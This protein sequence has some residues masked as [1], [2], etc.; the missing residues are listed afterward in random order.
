[1]LS[2][3]FRCL[4]LNFIFSNSSKSEEADK[5]IGKIFKYLSSMENDVVR[6]RILNVK[7]RNVTFE[8][9]CGQVMD[10]TFAELCDRPLGA[11]DYIE[12]SQAFHTVIIRDVP[13]LNL[14]TKSQARR[15]ITLIDTLYD[16]R[17][18]TFSLNYSR[19]KFNY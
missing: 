1:M 7:G 5:A 15:F 12:I 8:K 6:S 17:V 3:Y 10:S 18:G 19:Y 2:K 14:K 11:S 9:T 13:Q 4:Y 16:N